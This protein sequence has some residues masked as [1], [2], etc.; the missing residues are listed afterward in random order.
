MESRGTSWPS[1]EVEAWGSTRETLHMWLQIVGKLRMVGSPFVNHWWHVTFS[2]SA[3]GLTTGA[4]P[5]DGGVL[6]IEFDL[7]DHRLVLRTSDGGREEFALTAMTVA[8]FYRRTFDALG[9][10]GIAL[11][12]V[13]TPNEVVPAI[14]FAIDE[15]HC[16][17]DPGQVHAF[18][19]Q[20]IRAD[21]VLRRLRAEF[22]GKASPVHFFWG[23]LDLATT[24]FSGRPAPVHPGGVP[25]CPDRVMVEG[26][27]D[28]IS[29]SGFWPGGGREGA[30]YSYAYPEPAGYAETPVP[31]GAYYDPALGEFLLP[32]EV[33][34]LAEDPEALA[35]EFLRV[36]SAAAARLGEWPA[37]G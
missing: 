9:R 35:L 11:E 23:A 26:Y 19:Q 6:D 15:E 1:L 17:Y 33:V 4:I 14:P 34:R 27:S 12:I 5:V 18:W 13:P 31:E 32:Y 22:R 7:L 24:R 30:F 28:E 16:T 37:I 36:T 8:E 21:G 20:L 10:L 29:S 2:L 3:R 25:N